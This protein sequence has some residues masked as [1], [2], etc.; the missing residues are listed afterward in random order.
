MNLQMAPLDNPL[1]THPIQMGSKTCIE[2]YQ[3]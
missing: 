2:P 1:A 3:S